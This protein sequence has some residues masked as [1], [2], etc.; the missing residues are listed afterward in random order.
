MNFGNILS[1][2]LKNKNVSVPVL[3][4]ELHVVDRTVYRWI[5]NKNEPDIETLC[6]IC[7]FLDINFNDIIGIHDINKNTIINV[8][9]D[10]NEIYILNEYRKLNKKQ[11]KLYMKNFISVMNIFGSNK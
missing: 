1:I 3:A 7:V 10:P 2:A 5:E 9:Q 8:A 11:K 6:K 4:N